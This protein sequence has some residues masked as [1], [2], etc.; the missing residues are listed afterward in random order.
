MDF[1]LTAEAVTLRDL[2][3]EI[4]GDHASASRRSVLSDQGGWFDADAYRALAQ[5]GILG[6]ALPESVGGAG[7]EFLE[8]HQV[9]EQVGVTNAQVPVWECLVL[10]AGPI[11]RHGSPDQQQ[12]HLPR[13]VSGDAVLTGA[14]IEPGA[15]D[16]LSPRTRASLDGTWKL[17]GAKTQVPMG[18]HA[19][20]VLVSASVADGRTGVFI[21]DPNAPGVTW[22]EQHSV[23]GRPVAQLTLV[24]A[25]AE[26]VGHLGAGVLEDALLRAEAGLAAVQAGVCA[27]ALRMTADYT[28][29]REQF[30]QPL[31]AFQAVRQRLADAYIDVE[32]VRLTSLQAAW[33]LS[34]GDP[35][36]ARA[37]AIAKYWACEAGHRV[38][39]SA[40]H[41]HGGMGIDLDYDLHRYYRF[42]KYIEMTLGTARDQLRT[43][44]LSMAGGVAADREAADHG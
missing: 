3:A 23:S 44:G 43:L 5:A 16:R 20:A 37:V 36:A 18:L 19:D 21:I 1:D 34:S 42:G 35:G 27:K 13:V 33:M 15:G 41:L 14:Y 9:L 6:A 8:L 11:V 17:S 26:P 22:Q 12:R 25:P 24:E 30:G 29:G 38:L 40:H 2:S 4:L 28:S 7:L 32:A 39:H 31:A 10:G